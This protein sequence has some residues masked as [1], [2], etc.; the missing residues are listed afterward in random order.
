MGGIGVVVQFEVCD[1][2]FW[3]WIVEGEFLVVVVLYVVYVRCRL[4]WSVFFIGRGYVGNAKAVI[5]PLFQGEVYFVIFFDGGEV[6]FVGDWQVYGYLWL[7]DGGDWVV[8]QV[9]YFVGGIYFVYGVYVYCF[10]Y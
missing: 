2:V 9:D 6:Y 5:A 3:V 7:V 10:G 8:G 4:Y 1:N